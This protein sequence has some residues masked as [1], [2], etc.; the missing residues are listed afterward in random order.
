MKQWIAPSLFVLCGGFAAFTS[1]TSGT[2]A[3]SELVAIEG[4]PAQVEHWSHRHKGKTS[5]GVQF[6]VKDKPI[7]YDTDDPNYG[8]LLQ[9]LNSKKPVKF[10][11]AKKP[12]PDDF[13]DVYKISIGSKPILTYQ[14]TIDKKKKDSQTLGIGAGV[15]LLCGLIMFGYRSRQRS[16]Y[17]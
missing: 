17:R 2:A 6:K 9:A 3:E 12:K 15:L 7:E 4:T 8:Q 10:W 5:E 14:Q 1:L 11:I 13:S 16:S